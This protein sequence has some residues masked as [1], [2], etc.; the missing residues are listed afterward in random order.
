MCNRCFEL[1][2]ICATRKA[3][4]LGIDFTTFLRRHAAGDGAT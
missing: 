1:G 2:P 3:Q 4:S